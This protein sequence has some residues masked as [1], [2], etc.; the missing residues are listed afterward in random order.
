[1]TPLTPPPRPVPAVV[2][3]DDLV[4]PSQLAAFDEI[5]AARPDFHV[6]LYS[7]PNRLG[8]VFDLTQDHPWATFAI[9]GFEHTHFECLTWT[10]DEACRLLDLSLSMGYAPIFKAPNWVL[11]VETEQA[12]KTL[13][14][15]LHHHETYRPATTGLRC[16]RAGGNRQHHNLHTHISPNASTD[17]IGIHPGFSPNALAHL[18]TFET[19]ADRAFVL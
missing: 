13:G 10:Y 14:I 7:V 18:T 8:Q 12:C 3:V 1:M 16:Y 17:W 6:T 11:D 2:D 9:H 15:I 5:R 4:H 19:I